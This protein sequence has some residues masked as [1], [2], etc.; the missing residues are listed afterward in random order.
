LGSGNQVEDHGLITLKRLPP[1]PR[2]FFL[3]R[4]A[5]A[6]WDEVLQND[7]VA[8]LDQYFAA[9]RA[10]GA[11][12]RVPDHIAHVNVFET[13]G[14]GDGSGV[15]EDFDGGRGEMGCFI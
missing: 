14:Q 9:L 4:R 6:I 13:F 8:S 5:E 11:V 15:F 12:A 7:K 3:A 10:I 1:D 2:N